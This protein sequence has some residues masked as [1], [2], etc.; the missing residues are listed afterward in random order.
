MTSHYGR[1]HGP[2]MTIYGPYIWIYGY[3]YMD[4]IYGP[5]VAIMYDIMDTIHDITLW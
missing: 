3:K 4:H 2:Y 5:Y 1:H